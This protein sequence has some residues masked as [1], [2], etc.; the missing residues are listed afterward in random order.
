[1]QRMGSINEAVSFASHICNRTEREVGCSPLNPLGLY[2][3]HKIG[4]HGSLWQ[5]ICQ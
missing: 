4:L 5:N 3:W 1:M 2:E